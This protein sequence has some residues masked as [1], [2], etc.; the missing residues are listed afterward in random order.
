MAPKKKNR[1]LAIFDIDGTIFRSSLL[2]ELTE[3]FIQEGVF[4]GSARE[5]YAGEYKRWLDRKG[6]YEEYIEA[7]VKA[8]ALH[9]KGVTA[10]QFMAV[11]AQVMA[12]HKNRVYRYTRDLVAQLKKK[13]YTLLAISKSPKAILDLFCSELGFDKVYGVLYELD[14]NGSYTG[15]IL[16]PDIIL[17]KEKVLRRAVEKHGLSLKGSIGVGDTESDI[18]FLK[19]VSRPI[20]FNPNKKLYAYA[21]RAKWKVVVERKDA[22]YEL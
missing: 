17:D 4:D 22:V 8:F 20:C 16:Y 19:H 21:K 10:G 11:A 13:G 18:A 14:G 7:V 1:P 9:L 2:I 15:N 6:S 5:V 3:A 12:F